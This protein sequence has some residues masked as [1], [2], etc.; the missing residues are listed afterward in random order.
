M[1]QPLQ[2][3]TDSLSFQ[4][5]PGV[6]QRRFSITQLAERLIARIGD[7]SVQATSMVA[8]H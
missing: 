4:G 7:Q 8:E 2:A 1:A 3:E 6:Q 5:K